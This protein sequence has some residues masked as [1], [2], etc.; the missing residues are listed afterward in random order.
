MVEY[1]FCFLLL[2]IRCQAEALEAFL[3]LQE[4]QGDSAS[5]DT[6]PNLLSF[7]LPYHTRQFLYVA[8]AHRIAGV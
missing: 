3:T 6:L 2:K 7:L 4:P 8:R 1:Q 5:I